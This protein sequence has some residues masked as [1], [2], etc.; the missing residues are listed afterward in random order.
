MYLLDTNILIYFFK[1]MGEVASHLFTHEPAEIAIPAIVQYEIETGIAKSQNP[2]R[3]HKQFHELLSVITVIPFDSQTAKTAG[4]LRA[5]LEHRGP[6]SD[7]MIYLSPEQRPPT[8]P[9]W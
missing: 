1:G 5:M 7:R 4:E 6:Q 2:D 9:H 3:Q 8:T